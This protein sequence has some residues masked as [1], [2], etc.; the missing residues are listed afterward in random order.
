MP[1]I[2]ATLEDDNFDFTQF[3]VDYPS[4]KRYIFHVADITNGEYDELLYKPIAEGI[5]GLTREIEVIDQ[6]ADETATPTPIEVRDLPHALV[7]NYMRLHNTFLRR[8]GTSL[9]A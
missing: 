9:T 7:A 5:N 3:A 1:I 6:D 2:T 8:L 4:G